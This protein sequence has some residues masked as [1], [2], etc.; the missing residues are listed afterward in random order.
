MAKRKST[1]LIAVGILVLVVSVGG[2]VS[3]FVLGG[4]DVDAPEVVTDRAAPPEDADGGDDPEDAA[5]VAENGESPR[6]DVPDDAQAVALT[7]GRTEGLAG[8]L[9]AG[10]RVDVYG[11]VSDAPD[12]DD[13]A[14]RALSDVETL[15][16]SDGDGDVTVLLA[17]S[18]DE[19]ERAVF[20]SSFERLWLS[21]V[22]DGDQPSDTPGTAYSDL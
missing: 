11:V 5:H 16:V 22:G 14:R 20:L 19:V 10:D 21:L 8:H 3:A 12:G 4:D 15:W 9:R 2:G 13:Q 1:G 6:V 18:A 7:L 17:L